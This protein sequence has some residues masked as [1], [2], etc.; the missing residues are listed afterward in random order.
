MAI[1]RFTADAD[2][3]ISNALKNDLINRATGSN[4]TRRRNYKDFT[5]FD[6]L[7]LVIK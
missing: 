4:C 2:N 1:K 7:I 3:T 5:D 6:L